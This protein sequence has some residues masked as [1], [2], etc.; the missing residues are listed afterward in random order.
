MFA[1][2]DPVSPRPPQSHDTE[3]QHAEEGLQWLTYATSQGTESPAW[4]MWEYCEISDRVFCPDIGPRSFGLEYQCLC[5]V[6]V[7]IWKS[8]VRRF[9][10]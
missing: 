3:Y 6:V 1:K 8:C 5:V 9:L 4:P 2:S 10:R 7:E